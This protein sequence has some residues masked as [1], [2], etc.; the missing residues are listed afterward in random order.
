[1]KKILFSIVTVLLLGTSYSQNENVSG[2]VFEYISKDSISP[3]PGVNVYYSGTTLGTITNAEGFFELEHDHSRHKLVFSFIGFQKDTLDIKHDQE[4]NIILKDG[5]ILDEFVVEFRK[6]GYSFS[7]FD[8]RDAHIITTGELRKAACCN[9][10]ESFETNPSIDASFTD[11]VTG[12]KQIEM[13]GLSGKYVQILSGNI[14]TVRGLAVIYGL[15]QIPGAWINGISVSKGA[16][17]VLNGYESMV[18]QI[19]LDLKQPGNSEKF[20]L[21]IYGNQGGRIEG[22]TYF[23]TKVGKKWETTFLAHAKNQQRENDRN[24]DG[25]LDNPLTDNYIFRNQWNFRSKK[26]HMELGA[27]YVH[28]NG[29]SGNFSLHDSLTPSISEGE[30]KVELN[31]DKVSG[32]TKIGYLFPNDDF[33]SLALQLSGLYNNQTAL[34]GTKNYLGKQT[35]GYANIIFQQQIGKHKHHEGEEHDH[36]AEE[37][38]HEGEEADNKAGENYYKVGV[39][40]Q[41]DNVQ[42]SLISPDQAFSMN[43]DYNLEEL[44]PGGYVEFTHSSEKVGLVAGLRGDYSNVYGGFVTPRLHLRYNITNETVLK[45]MAGSGRRT[46]MLIMENVGLLASSR[47]WILHP[48]RQNNTNDNNPFGLAQEI[49]WNFGGA[50]LQ[51]FELFYREGS[52]HADFYHTSFQNQLIVDLDQTAREV[53][54]YNLDG[55]SVSNSLQLELNYE[56]LKRFDIRLAYRYLD[57]YKTYTFQLREKPLLSKHRAFVNLAYETKKNKSKQWKFD[58]TTQ[59]IGSQRIPYT[60]DNIPEF[61]LPGRSDDYFLMSAQITRIFGKRLELYLGAENLLNYKQT[62]PILSSEDPYG[63]YFES[64]LVWAPVFG[65]MIYGGLRFTV[66]EVEHH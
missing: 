5:E 20:H 50:F 28:S 8:P 2:R 61:V 36:E 4:I 48:N 43:G 34:F 19:N 16:G 24:K 3:L 6:G 47:N 51:E 55:I 42:E 66:G 9:L 18:G 57:V 35:S 26:I 54:F 23:N 17:S 38:S 56:L 45:L 12:T 1:M 27:N 15:D 33:K 40:L 32:F 59:W 52:F 29:I 62:N 7:K 39:S 10:A 31:T 11:A 25:F 64:S 30:Y 53:Q 21:N 22:N 63:D 58:I 13:L 65:R 41:Y 44:I 46:P 60:G 37:Q 14:P 49:S